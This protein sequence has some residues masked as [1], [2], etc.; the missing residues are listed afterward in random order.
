MKIKK[1]RPT[2]VFFMLIVS[3]III[4]SAKVSKKSADIAD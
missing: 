3:L 1:K 4:N 2:I